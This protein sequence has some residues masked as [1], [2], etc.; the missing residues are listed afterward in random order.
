LVACVPAPYELLKDAPPREIG[1]GPTNR[2]KR[3]PGWS[4]AEAKLRKHWSLLGFEQIPNSDVFALS[5]TARRPSMET[6]MHKYFA[7]KRRRT[8]KA[9]ADS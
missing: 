9:Q 2:D 7:G 1:N 5:L 6:V 3:I 8:S 4:A